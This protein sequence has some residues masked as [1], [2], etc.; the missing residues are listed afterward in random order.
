VQSNDEGFE[1]LNDPYGLL[2]FRF[3]VSGLKILHFCPA[4]RYDWVVPKIIALHL[5]IPFQP[6]VDCTSS[7][8]AVEPSFVGDASGMQVTVFGT[9]LGLK[10]MTTRLR[11]GDTA[12]PRTSWI[13]MSSMVGLAPEVDKR[14]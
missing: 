10:D 6:L 14:I 11:I 2:G 4:M 13:S 9:G 3:P 12:C 5:S 1:T 7:I 8:T